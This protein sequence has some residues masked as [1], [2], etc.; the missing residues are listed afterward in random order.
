MSE[1]VVLV[2][3]PELVCAAI[4]RLARILKM[5]VVALVLRDSEGTMSTIPNPSY[6]PWSVFAALGAQD[7]RRSARDAAKLD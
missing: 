7:W 4:D 5:E 1:P 2:P 6:E 3:N